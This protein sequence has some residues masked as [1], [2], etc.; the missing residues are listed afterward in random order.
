[1]HVNCSRDRGRDFQLHGF[2]GVRGR[3]FR[4][5]AIRFRRFIYCFGTFSVKN[6]V[7]IRI[8]VVIVM[9][10]RVIGSS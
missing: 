3:D 1:M 6:A 2:R 5:R 4:K 7:I 9:F 8:V 10:L